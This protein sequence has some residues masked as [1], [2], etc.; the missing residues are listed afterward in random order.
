[1]LL[2]KM[3][4]RRHFKYKDKNCNTLDCRHMLKLVYFVY[5]SVIKQ[6]M[7]LSKGAVI[8]VVVRYDLDSV[9]TLISLTGISSRLQVSKPFLFVSYQLIFFFL[10]YIRFNVTYNIFKPYISLKIRAQSVQRLLRSLASDRR[11][12][13]QSDIF[14]LCIREIS[15]S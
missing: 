6:S 14:L 15:T 10:F 1:M 5:M 12:E 11:M 7:T 4:Q 9:T 8:P 3:F 13:G 2:I